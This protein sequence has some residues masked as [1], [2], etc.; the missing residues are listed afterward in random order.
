[1]KSAYERAMER[2]MQLEEP[3]E[4]QKLE[5]E[6]GP[7][8][9]RLAGSYLKGQGAPFTTI[10]S[11]PP[12]RRVH[13]VRGM[14]EAL[15]SNLQ[16][17]K[18]DVANYTNT[19]VIEGIQRLLAGNPGVKDLLERVKYVTDQYRQFGIPQREQT[20]AQLKAQFENQVMASMGRQMGQ[21]APGMQ[22]NVETMP[23]FQQQWL[24]VSSQMDSQYEQHLEDFR[25]QL[26]ELV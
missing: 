2:A 5:W 24:A 4:K 15:V 9:R 3:D 11:E 17:P 19:K 7:K 8:G 21:P 20:Y 22:V 1:M 18:N 12:D 26:M 16:L 25:K 6:L 10:E 13:L 14:M 23:E